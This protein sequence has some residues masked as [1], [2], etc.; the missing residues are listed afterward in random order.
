MEN[1]DDIKKKETKIT[2]NHSLHI[3]LLFQP[4]PR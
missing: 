3:S 2:Q 1:E 4:P